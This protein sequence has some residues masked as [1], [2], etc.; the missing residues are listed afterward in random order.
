MSEQLQTFVAGTLSPEDVTA[1]AA[2]IAQGDAV[3]PDT[4]AEHLPHCLFVV[5]KRDGSQVVGVGAIKG[6]RSWYA[7]RIASK[8]KSGFEFDPHMHE[9][10][11][12][13]TRE[14]HRKRGISKEITA[15]LLSLFQGKPVWATT[16]NQ[17]M[18]STLKKNGFT[19]KGSSWKSKK[20]D[21]LQLWIKG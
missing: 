12:V 3:D 11:Y 18:E 4:A 20:G 13:V 5:L 2:L 6:Q 9:L 8:E 14:S 16:S 1:C 7:K 15:K 21:D 19:Q 17:F 10:G